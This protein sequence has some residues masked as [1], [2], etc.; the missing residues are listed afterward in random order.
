MDFN[1]QLQTISS[2][3]LDSLFEGTPSV[4]DL[5][6]G[7]EKTGGDDNH[8]VLHSTSNIPFVELDK[9]GNPIEEKKVEEPAKTDDKPPKEEKPVEEKPAEGEAPKEEPKKEPTEEEK[10]QTSEILKNT[11]QYLIDKGIWKDFDEKENIEFTDELY[12][13]LSAKQAE[14]KVSDL[15]DE[16]IDSTGAYGKAI[17]SHIKAGGNPDEIIDLFKEQKQVESYDISSEDG[18]KT[19]IE[20]YYKEVVGWSKSK[21][22]EFLTFKESK[23]DGL[24]S[25]AK[26]VQEKFDSLY[27]KQLEQIQAQEKEQADRVKKD[28]EEYIKSLSKEIEVFEEFTD[29]DKKLVKDSLLKFNKK[30]KDGTKVNDFYV[31]FYEIQNDPKKYIELVHWVMDKE[32]YDKKIESKKST[33]AVEKSWNF[34]KGNSSVSKKNGDNLPITDPNKNS[35]IDFSFA[36]KK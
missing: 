14:A 3:Q 36:F 2:E 17:I 27:S 9:D 18:Q 30:L 21:V 23:E 10:T 15:F 8:N 19:I 6:L 32:A 11:T 26:E 33:K 13:E 29:K 24:A 5:T 20:K 25:E 28:Q 22:D 12:A 4:K 1:A 34:V 35:K 16:L 31:K 7:D